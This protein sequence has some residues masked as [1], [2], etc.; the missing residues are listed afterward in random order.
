MKRAR[1]KDVFDDMM[2]DETARKKLIRAYIMK[3]GA[4]KGMRGGK[5]K[6]EALPEFGKAMQEMEY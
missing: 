1:K 4:P 6:K 5:K 2:K 3:C